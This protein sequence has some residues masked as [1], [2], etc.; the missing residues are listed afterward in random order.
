VIFVFM[1]IVESGNV[2]VDC[3]FDP[4]DKKYVSICPSSSSENTCEKSSSDMIYDEL[5]RVFKDKLDK[6]FLEDE[7]S[8]ENGQIYESY[9]DDKKIRKW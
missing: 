7:K 1:G 3:V 5:K 4:V 2:S 9:S 8:G 6:Q